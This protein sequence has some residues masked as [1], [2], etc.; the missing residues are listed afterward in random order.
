MKKLSYFFAL[1]LLITACNDQQKETEFQPA[2]SS[3]VDLV[4][5]KGLGTSG[6][7]TIGLVGYGYDA[8]GFC[9][10]ISVKA[11][12]LENLSKSDINIDHPTGTFPVLISGGNF[13]QFSESVNNT[14]NLNDN[15]L[16]LLLHLKSLIKL[17]TKSDTIDT[18]SA[19][20]YYALKSYYSHSSYYCR[21]D[22][23]NYITSEFKNDLLTLSAKE[24]VAKYGTHVLTNV[25]EGAKFEI[26]YRFKTEKLFDE[27]VAKEY[28]Q[29]RM[30]EYT[31]GL[32]LILAQNS[33][34]ITKKFKTDEQFIYNS[35]G[36][37]KKMCGSITS[38]DSN[39]DSITVDIN[40]VFNA[41]NIKP[42]FIAIG[43]DGI[44]PI[45][46]LISDETKKQEVKTYIDKYMLT[47][48]GY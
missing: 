26:L 36:S 20:V 29:T 8:T 28:F 44:L 42:Q 21:S 3:K 40:Q 43:K 11:K 22:I 27:N 25:Y 35:I 33:T 24:L 32:A 4:Y 45:Y 16:L 31:G 18:K 34:P 14:N 19:Y 13:A 39:P 48:K 10:T 46:E 30:K 17:A 9:D 12:V 7:K 47:A 37:R 5:P 6:D 23:K 38:T 41:N 15:G 1:V 2:T